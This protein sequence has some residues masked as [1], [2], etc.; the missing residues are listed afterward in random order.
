MTAAFA[1][2][3]DPDNVDRAMHEIFVTKKGMRHYTWPRYSLVDHTHFDAQLMRHFGSTDIEDLWIPYF[4][5]TAN[6]SRYAVRAIRC[7]PLW[8]AVRATGSVP[9]LLPPFYTANGEML[10]D[11]AL[12]DNVP[13]GVMQQLKSGPNVVV[14]FKVPKLER[15]DVDYRALPSRGEL[16]ASILNPFR[17]R[18][19]PRGARHRLGADACDDGKP[20]QLREAYDLRRSAAGAAISGRHGPARLATS[21][22]AQRCDIQLGPRRDRAARAYRSPCARRRPTRFPHRARYSRLLIIHWDHVDFRA[23]RRL[24]ELCLADR[25]T[26]IRTHGPAKVSRCGYA[27]ARERTHCEPV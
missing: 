20:R 11:G 8:Q 9:G 26:V 12:M 16:I 17:R 1:L 25:L 5:V 3:E 14:S 22:R 10:V 7:G 13:I 15:F 6:L 18:V 4:A 19:L 24:S 27:T 23:P 2:G 21:W